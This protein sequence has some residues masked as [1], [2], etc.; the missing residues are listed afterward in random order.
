MG[1]FAARAFLRV[2]L[3]AVLVFL[4]LLGVPPALPFLL[5]ACGVGLSLFCYWFIGVAPV[6]GGTK[7]NNK[8]RKGQGAKTTSER[9]RQ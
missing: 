5:F 2:V 1:F 6:R 8:S 7:T 9:Q 4:C 3:A